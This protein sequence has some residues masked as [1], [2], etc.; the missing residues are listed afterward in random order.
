[1]DHGKHVTLV[2][3][4]TPGNHILCSIASSYLDITKHWDQVRR[5]IQS[6]PM[7]TAPAPAQP[8]VTKSL[9]TSGRVS[10]T[11]IPQPLSTKSMPPPAP[12]QAAAPSQL[13]ELHLEADDLN[14][15]ARLA[16]VEAQRLPEDDEI[17]QHFP[18]P[19][20]EHLIPGSLVR[21]TAHM[22][23]EH[24][25]TDQALVQKLWRHML[26]FLP[27]WGNRNTLLSKEWLEV[28]VRAAEHGKRS[29]DDT[30]CVA[31]RK[32]DL[33]L[34]KRFPCV[35]SLFVYYAQ[36]SYAKQVMG[37]LTTL[38]LEKIWVHVRGF[39]TDSQLEILRKQEYELYK[40][41]DACRVRA[42]RCLTHGPLLLPPDHGPHR[43]A[44]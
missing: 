28:I 3:F 43:M 41:R 36:N 13:V 7:R 44:T 15:L 29:P 38:D 39:C 11:T 9:S 32:M 27:V 34:L 26:R 35:S 2:G 25:V 37:T 6:C 42:A 31:F 10:V 12:G 1:M 8:P 4:T 22:A 21:F 40:V 19:W 14:R 30:I 24:E 33:V 18:S 16:F 17:R 20:R 5:E 23:R